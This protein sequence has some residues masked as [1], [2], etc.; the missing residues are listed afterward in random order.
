[1]KPDWQPLTDV[2]D[3][4]Y[5][6]NTPRWVANA[7]GFDDLRALPD[8]ELPD[9]GPDSHTAS[10]G[11]WRIYRTPNTNRE[12]DHPRFVAEKLK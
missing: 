12:S 1:M 9:V 2:T 6:P 5:D 4:L 11:Y 8:G 10:D 7:Y 3:P